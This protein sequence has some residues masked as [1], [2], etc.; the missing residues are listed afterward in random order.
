MKSIGSYFKRFGTGTATMFKRLGYAFYILAHPF[1]GFFDLKNDPKR[2]TVSGSV[3]LLVML[4]ISSI[5][6]RQL[7]GYLFT[8]STG[9]QLYLNVGLEVLKAV[10]PF[11]LFALAN[12]CFTSLMDGDGSLKDIFCATAFATLPMTI[13]NFL[14][15]P[16]SNFVT[17]E[18][19]GI[20]LFI[21]GFSYVWCYGMVFLGMLVT[22]QYSVS[23]AIATAVLSIVGMLVI[24]FIAVLIFYLCQQVFGFVS[25]LYTEIS[26]RLNE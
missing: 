23:K 22:H 25:S 26:F 3:F 24:I 14:L 7:T 19:E 9:D 17:L 2:R 21:V 11:L 8:E 15:V 1:D 12:W 6:K 4:A 13:C 18:E 5:V 10:A 20:Y 16:I